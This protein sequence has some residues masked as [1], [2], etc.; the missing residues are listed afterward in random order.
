MDSDARPPPAAPPNLRRGEV[1]RQPGD[2]FCLFHSL[3]HGL[4]LQNRHRDARQL[5]RKLMDWL[6]RNRDASVADTTVGD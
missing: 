6:S 5:T 2:G 4:R 1:I 3:A